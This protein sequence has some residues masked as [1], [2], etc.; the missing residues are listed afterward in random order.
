MFPLIARVAIGLY[1]VVHYLRLLPFAASLFSGAGML[2]DPGLNPGAVAAISPL[3]LWDSP[4]VVRA[5]VIGLIG[6]ACAYTVGLRTRTMGVLLGLGSLFLWQRNMLTLNP[7]LP[8]LG[9]WF[10]IQ[11]FTAPNP[12][13]SVDRGLARRRG[14]TQ[15]VDDLPGDVTAALWLVFTVAY[16]Y[17]GYTKLVSPSWVSGQAVGWMLNGPIGLDNPLAR[18]VAGLPEPMLQLCTWGV[19]AVELLA[20]LALWTR[21]RPWWWLAA[22]AMHVG[23]LALVDLQDISWGMVV[24]HLVLVGQGLFPRRLI[25]EIANET[26]SSPAVGAVAQPPVSPP[27]AVVGPSPATSVVSPRT[28]FEATWPTVKPAG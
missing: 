25:P 26:A 24:V 8:F 7:S 17:S 6:V 27:Q 14:V 22:L 21:I 18:F 10:A 3:Y 16:S 15:F 2:A 20:P 4:A 28:P 19:V 13:G 12:R 23:L 11:A 5:L 9:F 1:L